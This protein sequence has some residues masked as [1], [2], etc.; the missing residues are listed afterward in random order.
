M[1]MNSRVTKLVHSQ[2]G[3]SEEVIGEWMEARGNRDQ[4]ILSTKVLALHKLITTARL[5]GLTCV[6]HQ[7]LP[8]RGPDA[9]AERELCR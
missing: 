8:S 3:S 7:Q 6:V 9:E 2:D 4:I 1:Q 5:I